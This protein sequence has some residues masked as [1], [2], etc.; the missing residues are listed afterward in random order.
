MLW[1]EE[2]KKKYVSSI[3]NENEK[4]ARSECG[5]DE[6]LTALKKV[7][8]LQQQKLQLINNNKYLGNNYRPLSA[9]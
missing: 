9:C 6:S 8:Q 1:I 5:Q 7:Q 3:C 4:L 2:E